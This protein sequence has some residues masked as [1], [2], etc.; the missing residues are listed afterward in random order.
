MRSLQ[1]QNQIFLLKIGYT[2][3][4]NTKA[5]WIHILRNKYKVMTPIPADIKRYNAS[6]LWRS[7]TNIWDKVKAGVIWGIKDGCSINFWNDEWVREVGTLQGFYTGQGDPNLSIRV[8][9]VTLADGSWNL[10]WMNSVLPTAIVAHIAT[11]E[12]PIM[13]TGPDVIMWKWSS[14]GLFSSA[15][16]YRN[17]FSWPTVNW[18]ARKIWKASV[19][20]R[21]R[22]FIWLL[23]RD[24]LLT[25]EVRAKRVMC[26]NPFY[27]LCGNVVESALH[28]TRDCAGARLVWNKIVPRENQNRVFGSPL[29]EW[30]TWNLEN[31]GGIDVA[32]GNWSSLF[33]NTC[34]LIWKNRNE[35]IF[36]QSYRAVDEIIG[37]ALAWTK[38]L[39]AFGLPKKWSPQDPSCNWW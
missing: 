7:L 4:V 33:G 22:M 30:A 27:D 32:S 8:R 35:T 24:S 19:P 16:T 11:H 14:A 31:E 9:D 36:G 5:F 38:S 15:E 6:H 37:T 26:T 1:S 28:A 2:I 3:L 21:V 12:P 17:N 34:W 18:D 10:S 25:N 29:V 13:G 20:Q 39:K 23:L